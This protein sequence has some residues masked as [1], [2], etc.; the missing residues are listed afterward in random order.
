MNPIGW[1]LSG[2]SACVQ[3]CV[4]VSGVAAAAAQAEAEADA[5]GALKMAADRETPSGL[6]SGVCF[7]LCFQSSRLGAT[8]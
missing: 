5:D 3:C 2:E 6:A 1:D 7:A 4:C 8:E